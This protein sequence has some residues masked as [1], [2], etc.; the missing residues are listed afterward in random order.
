[1]LLLA[2]IRDR[3]LA[4]LCCILG[5]GWDQPQVEAGTW[6]MQSTSLLSLGLSL[7][8]NKHLHTVLGCMD[9]EPLA[10]THW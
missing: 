4:L 1:M 5:M 2:I 7:L 10:H 9:V 3:A 8:C 6:P